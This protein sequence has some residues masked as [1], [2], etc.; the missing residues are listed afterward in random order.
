MAVKVDRLTEEDVLKILKI[1]DF[2]HLSKDKI[3]DFFS[4]IPNMDPETAQ[5]A[6]EQ[7]PVYAG[8]VKEVVSEYKSLVENVI[9]NNS[10]DDSYFEGCKVILD[11]LSN[12]LNKDD[13]TSE[14]R[15][16]V[17]EEMLEIESRM[18]QKVTENKHYKITV[19]SIL[20]VIFMVVIGGLA[21]V[22]GVNTKIKIP[23]FKAKDD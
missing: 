13:I 1:S 2:R 5:K 7:F 18:S 19:I 14:D 12:I 22:L 15:R 4:M 6:I 20:S 21:S 17:I 23:S 11:S 9:N 8:T 16:Y 3:M 10:A